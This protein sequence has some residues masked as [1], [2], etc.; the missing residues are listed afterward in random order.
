[1]KSNR[2]SPIGRAVVRRWG[3]VLL[4]ALTLPVH[5]AL[6][7]DV[8]VDR[9][10]AAVSPTMWG[11]F[12]E[13]INYGADGGLYPERV[14][15]RSFEFAEPLMGWTVSVPAGKSAGTVTVETAGA[16]HANNPHF[17]RLQLPPGGGVTLA[18][19]GFFGVAVEKG[20]RYRFTVRCRNGAGPSPE[21]RMEIVGAQG[22]RLG[23][24][25]IPVMSGDWEVREVLLRATATDP[26]ARLV[27]TATGAGTADLDLVS[28]LPLKTWK[29]RPGGLRPDMVQRLADLKPGFIR[30]PGGCIVEGRHLTTRYQWKETIGP[31]S[32]RKLLVNRWN[33]E[34]KH[35]PAPDYYQSFGLGFFEYFQLCEDLGSE[36]LP[37]IN[38]G[39]ACQFNSGELVPLGELDPYVQDALDLIEF[40]NGPASSPWGKRRAAMGHPAPF[41]L[42]MIGIGN[43]QWGP[44]YVERYAAFAKVLKARH[45]EIQLI[46][47]AG[48]RPAD[49]L[50]QFLWPKLRELKADIVDEHCYDRPAWF[51]DSARRYDG[52]DRNGP[53]IFMGEY[54][55]QSDK[56][57]SVLN[58]NNWECALAEAAFMTG[59]ERNAD[60]VV[61]SSYAPL[62]GHEEGWQWRPNLIWADNLRSYGTPN[63]YVQQLFSRNR[64]DRLIPVSIEGQ[65][66]ATAAEPGLYASSTLDEKAG[67]VIIK[68]VNSAPTS[69]SAEIAL[70]GVQRLGTGGKKTVLQAADLKAEN[71]LDQPENVSPV[72]SGIRPSG[73][74]FTHE[75]P[76]W[77]MTVL[78]LPVK[79]R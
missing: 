70:N 68:V 49:D 23:G 79:R 32:E 11:V 72:T 37:I 30:F 60:V 78:R 46:S 50:F 19:E 42:K 12:F 16:L 64:G 71:S 76:R 7:I 9:P 8:A 39:M 4:V 45:P 41:G 18:N 13:D 48:P 51:L 40:A 75:F 14:K 33:D 15:N 53:K 35:R 63:Y 21:L 27:L 52:Y 43:E 69:R 62:F 2:N 20:E 57:V 5:A 44:Q 56:V 10:G 47:S 73:P 22:A 1:M 77:S 34:F 59:L 31:V 58:R 74:V 65:A 6:R 26:K 29:R 67:E 38:C 25:D 17:L 66:P 55:A 3:L 61:M 54:A 24:G 28:L 36:P